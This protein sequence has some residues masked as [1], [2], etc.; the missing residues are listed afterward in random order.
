MAPIA[1]FLTDYV[2][3]VLRLADAPDSVHLA[4][5]PAVDESLLDPELSTQM[6]LVRRLVELGRSARA[7]SGVRTRQPLG[8]ALVG[9]SGWA[10]LPEELRGQIA[11]ELNV[12][13]F[14]TL[15]SI[16]GDLVEYVVKP[17][18]RELG[19]RFGKQTPL[20]AKAITAAEPAGLT[21]ALRDAGTATVSAE[22]VGK[23]ELA[24]SDV[25]VTE[26]PR[27]GWA[28]ESAAGETVGL[29]LTV[30][31]ELRRAG[32]VREVIR[33]VQDARKNTGLDITDRIEL[34]WR[35]T[36]ADLDEALAEHG[37]EVAGE[38]LA[39]T[40]HDEEPEEDLPANRDEELHLT[41]WLRRSSS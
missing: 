20:V 41:F 1:P 32:L 11:D 24:P 12:Q 26:R 38:V 18:F 14:D 17:N 27:S 23:V 22:E 34:W 9:A 7:S 33:L 10:S 35:T 28:V 4:T 31:P 25:I 5:W 3:D 29:D 39:D 19:K 16:G 8:R 36:D 13:G 40:W 6:A 30:T 21:H 15:A 2:W 37:A